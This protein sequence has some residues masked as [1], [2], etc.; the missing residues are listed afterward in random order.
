MNCYHL[1][2]H[3]ILSVEPFSCN[4]HKKL[5]IIAPIIVLHKNTT[6]TCSVWVYFIDLNLHVLY[7][8]CVMAFAPVTY[9]MT[10]SPDRMSISMTVIQL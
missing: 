7:K 4:T 5:S 2:V 9:H 8:D 1:P 10:K 6:Y 3:A